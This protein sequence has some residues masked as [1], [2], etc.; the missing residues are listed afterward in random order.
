MRYWLEDNAVRT[1]FWMARC[2]VPDRGPAVSL[3]NGAVLKNEI[4]V[5]LQQPVG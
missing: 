4:R 3:S 1:A 5:F 2:L